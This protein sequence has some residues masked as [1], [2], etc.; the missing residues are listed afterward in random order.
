MP[1]V[2]ATERTNDF[3]LVGSL[4]HAHHFG[5]RISGGYNYGEEE[6]QI[7]VNE[8]GVKELGKVEYGE[9]DVRIG[10]YQRRHENGKVTY[11][12]LK[13]YIPQNPRT[14]PQQSWRANFT[15]GMTAWGNL[16]DEQ[17]AVYN[18][19]VK[20]RPLHGV[21]LYLREYLKSL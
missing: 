17:K 9:D 18:E 13:F 3:G 11:K 16:T 5:E 19:R 8:Y 4:G 15:A 7:D 21:N 6:Y 12:R 14:A 1:D 20:G 10:V 2:Q